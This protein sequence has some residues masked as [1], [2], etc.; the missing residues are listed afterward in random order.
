VNAAVYGIFGVRIQD[1]KPGNGEVAILLRNGGW[2]TV[3]PCVPEEWKNVSA[4]LTVL[5]EGLEIS[6]SGD[7]FTVTYGGKKLR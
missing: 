4:R 6:G 2:L 5:G 3:E 1:E 7:E